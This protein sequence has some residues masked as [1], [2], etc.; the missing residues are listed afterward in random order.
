MNPHQPLGIEDPAQ[1]DMA[2][3]GAAGGGLS[4]R[5]WGWYAGVALAAAAAGGAW[6]W[7]RMQ[8]SAAQQ[9]AARALWE[10]SFETP[11]GGQ[12]AMDSLRGKPLLLNFWATWCPPCI[13]ELPLLNTFYRENTGKNWQ[14]LGIAVDQLASVKT[15][16]ERMPLDFPVAMAGQGGIEL[17]RSLGNL[18]GGLP[19]TVLF[20]AD[21][22]ILQRKMGQ[23][24][25]EDLRTWAAMV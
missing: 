8:P 3:T 9:D 7:W 6:S 16:L 13:A 24:T 4:R 2:R 10:R 19:F 12:L 14:V 1:D 5:Q 23:A 11:S 15:F 22:R 25:A 17:V 18:Q 21:G 20:A